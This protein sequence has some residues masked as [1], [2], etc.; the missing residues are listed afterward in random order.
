VFT[1]TWVRKLRTEAGTAIIR[2]YVNYYVY[3]EAIVATLNVF[4]SMLCERRIIVT[5]RKLSRLTACIHAAGSLLYP[6]TW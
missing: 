2:I 4:A 5:S 3:E 6:M 1:E